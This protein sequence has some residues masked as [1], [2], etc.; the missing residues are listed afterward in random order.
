MEEDFLKLMLS[1]QKTM[2]RD[3]SDIKVLVGKQEENL[4]LHVYRTDL[5]EQNIE[6]LRREIIPLKTNY[7]YIHG[8]LKFLGLAA[9][10]VTLISSVI[11]IIKNFSNIFH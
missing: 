7:N 9:A 6:S 4:R 5:A 2:T 3:I 10:V 8:G 1:E 11:V